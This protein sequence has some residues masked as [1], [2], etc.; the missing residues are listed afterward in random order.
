[1][2]Q[3]LRFNLSFNFRKRKQV[4]IFDASGL[5]LL[6]EYIY[7]KDISI[8]DVDHM[9]VFAALR[10]LVS[11]KKSFFDYTVAYLKIFKPRYLLTTTSISTKLQIFSLISNSLLFKMASELTMQIKLEA[12]F[13]MFSK[14]SL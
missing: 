4:A 10:M 8:I 9:N 1:V 6:S 14:E 13:L 12:D 3:V 2:I 5:S 11:G 7:Q